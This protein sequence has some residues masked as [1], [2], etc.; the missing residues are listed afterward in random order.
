[1]GASGTRRWDI[2]P[3]GLGDVT[4]TSGTMRWDS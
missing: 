3:V 2:E 1:M 4:G